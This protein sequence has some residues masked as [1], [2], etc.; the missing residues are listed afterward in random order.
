MPIHWKILCKKYLLHILLFT[1]FFIFL[2][3]FFKLSKFTK[4]FIAGIEIKELLLLLA[5]FVYKCAPFTIA[6][7]SLAA[8][9]LVCD[10]AQKNGEVKAFSAFGFSPHKLFSPLIILSLFLSLGNGYISFVLSPYIQSS[11]VKI[12]KR[13]EKKIDMI[14]TLSKKK[15]NKN[16]YI[17]A[18][19]DGFLLVK[20]GDNFSW[21]LCDQIQEDTD[22]IQLL[23]SHTFKPIE[24]K[25]DFNTMVLSEENKTSISKAT[26]KSYI[27]FSSIRI[28][29]THYPLNEKVALLCYLLFPLT[30]T[31]LGITLSFRKHLIRKSLVTIFSLA[32]FAFC[33]IEMM[34]LTAALSLLSFLL[35]ALLYSFTIK[36]YTL[37]RL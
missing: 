29:N 26:L 25:N 24:E 32:S 23:N 34:Y 1:L 7:T 5:I 30:F 10:T 22:T 3:I 17:D 37:G 16:F 6:I 12:V 28:Q 33:T 31:L 8:S 21:I 36:K 18:T 35:S 4:Y 19:S 14:G 13:K 27:P 2:T 11:L 20:S 15:G 9:Y